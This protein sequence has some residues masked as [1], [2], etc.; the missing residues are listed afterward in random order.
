MPAKWVLIYVCNVCFE[1]L[2]RFDAVAAIVGVV[3]DDENERI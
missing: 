1:C 3:D 2:C